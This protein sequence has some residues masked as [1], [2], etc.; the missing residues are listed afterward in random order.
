MP[1]NT[2]TV[3]IE[4]RVDDQGSV[5]IKQLGTE[6][7]KAGDTAEKSFKKAGRSVEDF[8]AK[9]RMAGLAVA[10]VGTAMAAGLMKAVRA[11]SDLQETTSKFETVFGTQIEAARRFEKELT[12]AYA[13]STEEARRH[14][15]AMQDLLVPM[16]MNADAAARMS[17]EVVKLSAD[18]G[19]FNNLPTAQV[20]GDIQ[21]ALV[22]NY[23]TMKKYGVVLNATTVQEKALAMGLAATKDELTAA[24]KAQAAY[25][26]IVEGSTFAIGDMVRTSDSYANTLKR[27]DAAWK[28]VTAQMGEKFLPVATRVAEFIAANL[29]AAFETAEL[30][31]IGFV[32]GVNRGWIEIEYGLKTATAAITGA[33]NSMM[34]G[35][36]GTWAGFIEN[37]A[38]AASNIPE[39]F[40]GDV[41]ASLEQYAASIRSGI[42]ETDNFTAAIAR[43]RE[44]KQR[45]LEIHQRTIDQMVDEVLKH[46]ETAGAASAAAA[47][48][49]AVQNQV[50]DA[51]RQT[52]TVTAAN[53][54]KWLADINKIIAAETEKAEKIGQLALLE[55]SFRDQAAA[56]RMAKENEILNRLKFSHQ[57]YLDYRLQQIDQERAELEKLGVDKELIETNFIERKKALYAEYYAYQKGMMDRYQSDWEA[58]NEE[59]TRI[60]RD[61]VDDHQSIW[62]EMVTAWGDGTRGNGY[63]GRIVEA[64]AM[65][66]DAKLA[67]SRTANQMMGDLA[68]QL[69]Q[70]VWNAMIDKVAA[71]IGAWAGLGAAESG[72][73]GDSTA[74]RLAN[75]GI[76]IAAAIAAILGAKGA[77][78]AFKATGGWIENH[79]MGGW[80][81][82]GSG[83]F[84]DVFLGRTGPI[85]HW[86]MGGEFVV[87]KH[88]SRKWAPVLEEINRD[89]GYA[90]GGQLKKPFNNDNEGFEIL[91]DK[92]MANGI[93]AWWEEYVRSKNI[94]TAIM[95]TLYYFGTLFASAFGGKLAGQEIEWA[96]G[97]M[98]DV[99]LAAG[100]ETTPSSF[101]G[102][103]FKHFWDMFR[104][105]LEKQ[106][107]SFMRLFEFLDIYKYLGFLFDP[108]A[109]IYTWIR[110]QL[111]RDIVELILDPARKDVRRLLELLIDPG[112]FDYQSLLP[113]SES[114]AN[115]ALFPDEPWKPEPPVHRRDDFETPDREEPP[116]P[117]SL[118]FLGAFAS[119]G[120]LPGDGYY[121]GHRGEVVL[122]AGLVEALTRLSNGGSSRPIEV[123]VHLGNQELAEFIAHVAD[124]NRVT[125]ERSRLGPRRIYA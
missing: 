51:V 57:G 72:T 17:G 98:V 38:N 46:D 122:P 55:Q 102:D 52:G 76:Y 103:F 86:G 120:L 28:D 112:N 67:V 1:G 80:I 113:F 115:A 4:V 78:N 101:F 88:A 50:Q 34:D 82:E 35:L 23:E 64:W 15:A 25:K 6:T 118:S 117:T 18:L 94:Y 104:K 99:G 20:M 83:I 45:E 19:S 12:S 54:D 58:M 56:S 49:V 24:D 43:V 110:Q 42:D 79:P 123:H 81:K 92:I 96:Q 87:N 32:D 89:V 84:D 47:A 65:G 59:M 74:G 27:M 108:I 40:A 63:V 91:V 70:T 60:T 41:A 106:H 39:L 77:G 119:G 124:D 44:E 7:Q 69:A 61:T 37:L 75:I 107:R 13:M 90:Y 116:T 2:G 109:N 85:R 11:A 121:Y 33:W 111:G 62:E 71:M 125:A 36:R 26:M 48:K 105:F 68:G 14:L 21:S 114:R 97:G 93:K 31:A 73:E 29:P 8:N 53:L 95:H 5:K 30:V 10:A 16:G 22:G 100:G 66:E 3:K 9:I